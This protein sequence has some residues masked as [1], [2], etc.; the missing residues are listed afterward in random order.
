MKDFVSCYNEN[1]AI[2]IICACE[3]K[4]KDM[5]LTINALNHYP[6]LQIFLLLSQTFAFT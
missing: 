6:Q 3:H 5:C 1:T 4:I 2:Y